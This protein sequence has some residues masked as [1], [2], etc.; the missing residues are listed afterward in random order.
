MNQL[1]L[2]LPNQVAVLLAS[3]AGRE[4]ILDLAARLAPLGP[5][6]VLDGGN[7]FNAYVVARAVRRQTAALAAALDNLRVARAFT[8]Y[9]MLALL[10]ETPVGP[11]PTLVLDLLSTFYDE[12][13]PLYESRRLL[14]LALDQLERLG[15]SAPVVVSARPPA[16]VCRERMALVELVQERLPVYYL[17]DEEEARPALQPALFAL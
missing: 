9:Q 4:V 12:S 3:R 2:P 10:T 17:Y 8:C 13:V 15:A 1:T 7:H 11:A 16:L 14:E 5:L 6:R